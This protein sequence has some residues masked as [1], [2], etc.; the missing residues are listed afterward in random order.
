MEQLR[1]RTRVGRNKEKNKDENTK[2]CKN[3]SKS[4]Q[5]LTYDVLCIIFKYL[6]GLDLSNASQVCRSWLEVANSEKRTRGPSCFIRSTREMRYTSSS[7]DGVKKEI[8]E[9]S[10]VKPSLSV[11]FTVG[12]EGSLSQRCHCDY[13]PSNCDSISLNTYGVVINNAESE[14]DSENIVCMFFPEVPNIKI[15]TLTFNVYDWKNLKE[16]YCDQL[17]S[18]FETPFNNDCRKTSCLI[19]LC[20]WSGRSIALSLLKSSK[21]WF[22]NKR[23]SIWGGIAKNL[24]V[25]TSINNARVCKN[26]ANCVAIIISGIQMRTCSVL[27]D[28]NCN[29][30]ERV[31]DK[32]RTFKDSVQLKKH[33]IGFMFACCVR[34]TNTFK[35][36][37]VESTI[38]KGFFPRVPLVGCFGDGEFGRK[39]LN[40]TCKRKRVK[41]Y[42]S[43]STAFMILTYN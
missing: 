39:L 15:S 4:W 41:W 6:N 33:S 17:K 21:N 22:P 29:T 38:F 11:F 31:E 23:A 25:C 3:I 12:N 13:L 8:I 43:E 19:L 24:S 20:D 5:K 2:N 7:W 18:E 27:L 26:S 10:T 37:N 35:E 42:N 40:E 30:K 28:A 36:R 16:T 14:E 34:G 32:L 1:K 9:C